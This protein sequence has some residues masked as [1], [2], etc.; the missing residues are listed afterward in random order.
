[1]A[2]R[3]PL[4]EEERD[5]I[6]RAIDQLEGNLLYDLAGEL[7]ERLIGHYPSEAY[8]HDVLG[9]ARVVLG[10]RDDAIRSFEKAVAL[11]PQRARYH[12]NLGWGCLAAGRLDE[13][14]AHLRRSLQMEPGNEVT[15]GNREVLRFLE[16][17]GGT[18]EDY[19]L[20]PLDRR[21][22]ARLLK[23]AD[24]DGDYR[25][26]DRAAGEWNQSRLEAWKWELCRR[27]EPPDYPELH[28][29]VAAFLRFVEE[30]SQD[31]CVLYEDLDLLRGRFERVMHRFIFKM[32][33]AD[34]EIVEEIC[35]G[36]LSFYS[37]LSARGVVDQSDFAAFRSEVLDLKQ[38]IIEKAE[39]YAEVRHD[40]S[41]PEEEKERIREELF[42]GDHRW[43]WI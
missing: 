1:M 25:E 14:R 30:G 29:S 21:T 13:A 6:G 5:A 8:L 40:H 33:D 2:E 41:I 23:K 9:E 3:G 18:F 32:S 11:E 34:A 7:L 27:R 37:W 20:R 19:L 15:H 43:A 17:R 26:L 22:L 10:R 16:R 4:R 12:C 39:R 24:D 42:G 38:G 28:K 35:A 36:L 31:A